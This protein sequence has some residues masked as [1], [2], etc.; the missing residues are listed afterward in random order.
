MI[1][2]L[3]DIH[4]NFHALNAVINDLKFQQ[5]EEII[6]LGDLID[7][8]Q[9]SN[10]VIEFIGKLSVPI[11]CNLW[12]NHEDAVLRKNFTKFSSERGKNSAK[13]TSNILTDK[14]KDYLNKNCIKS[15][16]KEFELIYC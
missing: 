11:I 1:A 4:G 16:I 10:E 12:G 5:V 14:T 13:Y 8:G 2:I 3:S 7:Y 6:L 9:Q 15:G